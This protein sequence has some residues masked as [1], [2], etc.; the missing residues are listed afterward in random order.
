M[1]I[2]KR[3]KTDQQEYLDSLYEDRYILDEIIS[4][5][6]R[7]R[8]T[9][10]DLLRDI[11]RHTKPDIDYDWSVSK[12]SFNDLHLCWYWY[13]GDT[14]IVGYYKNNRIPDDIAQDLYKLYRIVWDGRTEV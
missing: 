5:H 6:K 7:N 12:A 1:N 8:K 9:L 10:L 11:V 2:F 13:R 4:E 3:N 14:H